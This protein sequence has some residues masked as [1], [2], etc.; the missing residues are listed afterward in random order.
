MRNS[1]VLLASMSR[2][3]IGTLQSAIGSI[4][5]KRIG[6]LIFQGVLGDSLYFGDEITIG[7]N[8]AA[9]IALNDGSSIK[10]PA[11]TRVALNEAFCDQNGTINAAL[12]AS[13]CGTPRFDAEH[14]DAVNPVGGGRG[15]PRSF[16]LRILSLAVLAYTLLRDIQQADALSTDDDTIV[17]KDSDHGTFEIITKS[18]DVVLVDDPALTYLVDNDGAIEQQVNTASRMEELQVAQQA[19]LGT[20]AQGF[21]GPPGSSTPL[22][23]QVAPDAQPLAI[24][25]NFRPLDPIPERIE[26]VFTTP[27]EER[28][29]FLPP[30]PP[31]IPPEI[32]T[33]T[34]DSGIDG[35]R[36]TNN[37]N[38]TLIGTATPGATVA[39]FDSGARIGTTTANGSGA[40]TF[41]TGPLSDGEHAFAVAAG[42][43]GAPNVPTFARSSFAAVAADTSAGP[44][45]APY[46]VVIDTKPPEAPIISADIADSHSDGQTN[47]TTPTL[48][49]TAESGST[50]DVYRNGVFVG[51][52]V[53]TETAGT[54]TFK[55]DAL[56]DGCYTFTATATD[57]AS[58]TSDQSRAFEIEIDGTAPLAPE[59]LG[60]SEHSCCDTANLTDDSTPKLLIAAEA[61]STVHVYRD[62]ALVGTARETAKAGLFTFT[63]AELLDGNYSFTATATDKADNVSPASTDFTIT[64]VTADPNDFDDLATGK[65]VTADPDGT[66]YGTSKDD[67][68]RFS[69]DDCEPGRTVYSGAGNDYVKG[70]GQDDTIYG[71]SGRDK[72]FGNGGADTIFGGYGNDIIA[73]GKG[74]D[75]LI[76][77]YGA[78][79]LSGGKG[80]DTFI[81]LS[82]L[83]SLPCQRDHISDFETG[84]D[85]IDLS[86][87]DSNTSQT[88]DQAFIFAGQQSAYAVVEHAVTWYYD[89]RSKHTYILADTDG[90]IHT[91]EMEIALAGKVNLT[92][93]DFLL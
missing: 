33:F 82:T 73:G 14:L 11:N 30:P 86:A 65:R 13:G 71:G 2:N 27:I 53:E 23:G 67:T 36:I 29:V 34:F 68:I 70:T 77:G 89:P 12:L 83:D 38:V 46:I 6:A 40:W 88:G 5:V 24:P 4:T 87:I 35:D 66:V 74:N 80:H 3:K 19:V 22:D 76:G 17:P 75:I 54:F 37:N 61:G 39:I 48:T 59:L 10:L 92:Q 91:A 58:N 44:T 49:I 72:I 62:G 60:L 52:A 79:S 51:T 1:G 90:D 25:I 69:H 42:A 7:A 16:G 78:D 41:D 20:L 63:S 81:F 26:P 64:V 84:R 45:S 85:K 57:I 21:A 8:S 9:T 56:G 32:T 15:R 28:P 50:V 93:V 55:S 47:D 43:P 18:G 31:P